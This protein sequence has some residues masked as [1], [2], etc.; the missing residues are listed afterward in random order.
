MR[1]AQEVGREILAALEAMRPF[2]ERGPEDERL[3]VDLTSLGE[4]FGVTG[5]AAGASE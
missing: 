3:P 1:S 2:L 5:S 4:A